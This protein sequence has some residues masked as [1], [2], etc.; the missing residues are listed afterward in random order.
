M[1]LTH[2]QPGSLGSAIH[3]PA[4]FY[5]VITGIL[6]SFVMFGWLFAAN[7]TPGLDHVAFFRNWIALGAFG[8]IMSIP[9]LRFVRTPGRI[10]TSGLTGWVLL[11]VA[12]ASANMYFENLENRLAK[13]PFKL[14]VMGAI[15]YAVAAAIA[16]IMTTI[17]AMLRHSYPVAVSVPAPR[18]VEV[19][20]RPQ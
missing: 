12:Y 14:L 18:A 13:T 20:T 4:F 16:W 2:H 1:S 8:F 17:V 10:F 9:V 7:R 19:P 6:L 3:H 11:C 15:V 5:G